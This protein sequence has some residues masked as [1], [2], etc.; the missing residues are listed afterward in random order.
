MADIIEPVTKQ[1]TEKIIDQMNNYFYQ[2]NLTEAGPEYGIFAKI[3]NKNKD[4]P[5]LIISRY[6]NNYEITNIL[7]TFKDN[8]I[9]NLEFG[10]TIYRNKECNL[11]IMEIKENNNNIKFVEIDETLFNEKYEIN[12]LKESIYII[13]YNNEN[14]IS[15]SYTKINN[16][17][18]SEIIYNNKINTQYKY[19]LIFNLSNNKLIGFHKIKSNNDYINSKN[20]D[21]FFNVLKDEFIKKYNNINEL[22]ISKILK[23]KNKYDNYNNSKNEIYI[24]IKSEQKDVEDKKE[25][26]FLSNKYFEKEN[27]YSVK[28]IEHPYDY[29]ELNKDNTELYIDGNL[30]EFK[31]YIKIENNEV[32]INKKVWQ[33]S[34]DN[35]GYASIASN[36]DY[37]S[38]TINDIYDL[39]DASEKQFSIIKSQL[40]YDVTR[41]HKDNSIINKINIGF[42]ASI[43]R[44]E[45]RL[46]AKKL[47]V[48]TNVMITEI[49]DVLMVRK[50]Q[51]VYVLAK[52]LN[53]RQKQ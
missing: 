10:D 16:I 5:I 52:T 30:K 36:T 18:E 4:I 3:K 31:K 14:D 47:D 25:L 21:I 28:Y 20:K 33:S 42:I 48:P 44:N 51:D 7:N 12:L 6:L 41:V 22:K 40:G 34:I 27:E 19:S 53:E 11:T 15:V 49:N 8:I 2:I 37:D 39:R 32:V 46:I 24:K 13:H 45:I 26:Y 1:C 29:K 17:N 35:K 23:N 50:R 43:I 9:Q 38:K